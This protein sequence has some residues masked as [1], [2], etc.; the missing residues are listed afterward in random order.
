MLKLSMLTFLF[1]IPIVTIGPAIAG[2]AKVLRT[3]Y[4][5]KDTFIW[6]E[7]VK[8]FTQNWKKSL[9]VG[10]IDVIFG[11]SLVC[12]LNVYPAL[13]DAAKAAGGSRH[14]AGAQVKERYCGTRAL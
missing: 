1:C 11:I 4:L 13:G 5:D 6:H 10:L 3:Y 7:F 14:T 9:P 8:G 2:M 12:A